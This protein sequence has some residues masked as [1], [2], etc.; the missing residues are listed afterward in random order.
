MEKKGEGR[1]GLCIETNS[2][3]LYCASQIQ[4]RGD[5]RNSYTRVPSLVYRDGGE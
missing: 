5:A 2:G 4:A 1:L 3:V